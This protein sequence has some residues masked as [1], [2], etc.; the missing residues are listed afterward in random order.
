M[1]R[2]LLP[3]SVAIAIVASPPMSWA[4]RQS[5]VGPGIIPLSAT[6]MAN[7]VDMPASGTIGTLSVSVLGGPP[8]PA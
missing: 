4:Q 7:G 1:N 6:D 2:L 5:A 3:L 8:A